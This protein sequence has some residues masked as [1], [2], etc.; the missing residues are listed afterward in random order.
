MPVTNAGKDRSAGSMPRKGRW[1]VLC[2]TPER[3]CAGVKKL[4]NH[5][6]ANAKISRAHESHE[7]AFDC[8]VRYLCRHEGY[9]QVGHRELIGPSGAI[10]VMTKKSRFGTAVRHGKQ[11][12]RQQPKGRASG[13]ILSL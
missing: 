11:S 5:G 4:M 9:L 6:L 10:R 3:H 13:V 2:G 8:H 7:S 1:M 12:M